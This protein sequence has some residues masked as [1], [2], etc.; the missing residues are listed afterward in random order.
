[1]SGRDALP[2]TYAV[3]TREN[4]AGLLQITGFTNNPRGVKIRYK[5][6]QSEVTR[7]AGSSSGPTRQ[8]VF[9][10]MV[11]YRHT[12]TD[13]LDCFDPSAAHSLACKPGAFLWS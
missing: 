8:K 1:M 7:N 13:R 3:K 11:C 10:Y 6:A 4:G 5:P 9:V 2:A 12:T